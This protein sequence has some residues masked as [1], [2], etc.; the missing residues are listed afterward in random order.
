LSLKRSTGTNNVVAD[1]LSR[2]PVAEQI[3]I[4]TRSADGLKRVNYKLTRT[5]VARQKLKDTPKIVEANDDDTTE[6][7]EKVKD[8]A[9]IPKTDAQSIAAEM[10]ARCLTR[11]ALMLRPVQ[12]SL[13]I[14][15]QTNDATNTRH[16]A[17]RAVNSRGEEQVLVRALIDPESE[18]SFVIRA[19][20]PPHS[21]NAAQL[22]KTSNAA[23]LCPES[24]VKYRIKTKASVVND[25]LLGQTH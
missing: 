1:C 19:S 5:R 4:M 9:E 6:S 16:C 23:L 25:T 22:P 8:A 21:Q 15:S 2:N 13:L 18:G 11:R 3:N 14:T 17:S 10:R 12:Q 24:V 7:T 20:T